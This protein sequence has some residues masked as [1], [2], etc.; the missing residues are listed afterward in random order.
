MSLRIIAGEK[1]GHRLQTP[2]GRPTR[3]TLGRVREALFT[4][5]YHER[6]FQDLRV[7]DLFAGSGALGLEALSR[8]AAHAV[9][10]EKANAALASL[11][12]NIQNLGWY[13]RTEIVNADALVYVKNPRPHQPRFGLI[14]LDP[15]YARDLAHKTLIALADHS[16][17]WLPHDGLVVAQTDVRDTLQDYYGPLARTFQ[18]SYSDTRITFYEPSDRV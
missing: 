14:L 11:R 1:K 6:E 17:A 2:K 9:F 12:A 7:L 15:P 8:G 18:R 10:V 13:E 5:L 16:A 3:P 4:K